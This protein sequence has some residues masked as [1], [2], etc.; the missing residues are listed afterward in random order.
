LQGHVDKVL[1]FVNIGINCL[2]ALEIAVR[3]K[4]SKGMG[5]LIFWAE[6]LDEKF[7]EG[8]P[9]HITQG[10]MLCLIPDAVISKGCGVVTLH[11]G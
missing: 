6:G 4:A 2:L 1:K 9:C 8:F 11:V 10:T 3:L 7:M 5:G